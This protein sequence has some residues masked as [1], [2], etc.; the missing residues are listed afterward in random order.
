MHWAAVLRGCVFLLFSVVLVR[1]HGTVYLACTPMLHAVSWCFSGPALAYYYF[2]G[3][4]RVGN[5]IMIITL[6]HLI[7]SLYPN[8]FGCIN[9]MLHAVPGA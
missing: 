7:P 4:M 6:S 9:A 1:M 5:I 8:I 2:G 3:Y